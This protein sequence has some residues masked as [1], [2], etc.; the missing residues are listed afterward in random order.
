MVNLSKHNPDSSRWILPEKASILMQEGNYIE[1]LFPEAGYYPVELQVFKGNCTESYIRNIQVTPPSK[2]SAPEQAEGLSSSWRVVPNPFRN[3]FALHAECS[4]PTDVKYRI[5]S[6]LT[7]QNILNG[8]FHLPAAT[9]TRI[10]LTEKELPGGTYILL[11]EHG[12]ERTA[13][14]IIKTN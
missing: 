12:S 10:T 1:I 11:L 8:Y 4:Q 13:I 5:L 2:Q 3:H 9:P 14:K 6:A 7:G